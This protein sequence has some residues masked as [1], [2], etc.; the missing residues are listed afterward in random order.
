VIRIRE[1]SF[2]F[3]DRPLFDDVSLDLPD[4]GLIALT[5]PNGVGKTT[6]LRVLGGVYRSR[7]EVTTSAGRPAKAIY[8]DADFL[9]L[10]TL[11]VQELLGLLAAELPGVAGDRL[12]GSP[13]ITD[14]MRSDAV[15]T[16]SLGQRQRCVI[17]VASSLTG[18][19]AVLLD[20]PFNALDADGVAVARQELADLARSRPVLFAT[21]LTADIHAFAH[22]VLQVDGLGGMTL[23]PTGTV[24]RP[25]SCGP[26]KADRALVA[27][28]GGSPPW[29]C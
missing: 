6:L 9:T 17:A 22:H 26:A 13:L 12:L 23:A 1:L 7:T 24:E 4:R 5:G 27:V 8:L 14:G 3:T 25:P 10:D 29:Q 11:T 2:G 19:D 18:V 28:E 16:L 21:H 20:E 15:G